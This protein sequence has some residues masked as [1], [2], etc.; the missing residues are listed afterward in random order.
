MLR[1]CKFIMHTTNKNTVDLSLF[2]ELQNHGVKHVT[3]MVK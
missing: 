3:A 1:N 2:I